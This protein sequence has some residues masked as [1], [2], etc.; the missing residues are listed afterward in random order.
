V[1]TP[2]WGVPLPHTHHFPITI[3]SP[4]NTNQAGEKN[5]QTIAQKKPVIYIVHYIKTP[6][7]HL[8]PS[9]DRRQDA[10]HGERRRAAGGGGGVSRA[11][12][13]DFRVGLHGDKGGGA[14][15]E[16]GGHG[17]RP[18][19]GPRR[20][21]RWRRGGGARACPRAARDQ[22]PDHREP[23]QE[24]PLPPPGRRA[25]GRGGAGGARSL[26]GGARA[27]GG[28]GGELRV[29]RGRWRARRAGRR[30]CRPPHSPPRSPRR[31]GRVF[32]P[33]TSSL[34]VSAGVRLVSR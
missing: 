3:P 12:G 34:L 10:G 1:A 27:G 24:A 11:I 6:L 30:R 2:D 17:A 8:P 21:R 28:R 4:I 5:A 19:R 13:V 23:H 18:G 32:P 9:P 33:F 14:D 26:A 7:G 25:V 16:A 29:R 15:G 20:R 22:E 31:E